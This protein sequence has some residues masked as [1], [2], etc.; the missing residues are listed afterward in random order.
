M[1]RRWIGALL[2]ALL[3]GVSTY[4]AYSEVTQKHFSYTLK[5]ETSF[6][7]LDLLDDFND[8]VPHARTINWSLREKVTGN[9]I[10]AAK[11]R[12]VRFTPPPLMSFEHSSQLRF[13]SQDI[14]RFQEVY[15]I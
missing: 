9:F 3:I 12:R 2:C 5:F 6:F 11:V 8:G 4:D 13:T 10:L 7:S 14:F 15:R 1:T